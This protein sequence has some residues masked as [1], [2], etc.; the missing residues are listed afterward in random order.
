MIERMWHHASTAEVL[1]LVGSDPENG[2]TRLEVESRQEQFGPNA[3]P[4]PRGQGPVLRFLL[5]FHQPLLYILLVAAVITA[6]MREWVDAS[7]IFGVVLVNAIIGFLQESKAAKALEAL[8]KTTLTPARVIRAGE[9]RHIDSCDLVTGDIVLLQ[10]GDKV[11]ADLRLLR[12]R[13]LKIDESALTGESLTTEKLELELPLETPLAERQNMSFASTLVTYGQGRGVVVAI[14]AQTEVGRI[15][16]MISTVNALETPL[17]RKI[18][19]FSRVLLVVILLLAGV[20]FAVGV[21]RGQSSFDMFMAAVALAVGAIPEGLPAAVTITLAIGVSRMARRRAIV[22]KLSAVE[23]LGSTTVI[24]SDKT[25]TLTVNQ[26]TVL[27]IFAGEKLYLT[28]GTGYEATGEIRAN[29]EDARGLADNVEDNVAAKQCLRAGL[30]CNDS[31]LVRGESRWEVQGD[32]TEGA[33]I[34]AARK[35]GLDSIQSAEPMPRQDA[36]PFE[37]QYQY[38]ATL[39]DTCSDRARQ[40]IVKG[41]VEVVL[42]KCIVALNAQ[43]ETIPLDLAT[44]NRKV[45]AMAAKGLRVLA[46]AGKALPQTTKSIT[47][48]DIGELVFF[49]LQGMIDPPRAEALAAIKACQAAGIR[50]KM[51]TGDHALTAHAIARQLGLEGIVAPGEHAPLVRT[52]FDLASTTDEELQEIADET[53]VFARATPELK[54]RLVRALQAKG[55]IVA[56][57]GDGVN[58]AP[59][60]KQANIGVAM[61]IGGTE[62][63]KE[64][65]DMVLT[66]DNFATIEAAVEEGRGVFENLTKYIVWNLPTS[67]GEGLVILAA[68]FAG[69]P[70]PILP[71]QILWINMT[72]AVLLGVMLAFEPKESEIMNMPPRNPETPIL[73]GE[74]IGRIVVVS[75]IMLVGAFGSFEWALGA[76]YN[77]VVART[78]AVNVFVVVELFYLFNCRSLHKSIVEIGLFSNRWIG[79]GVASM[80]VLQ[81]A[82]TYAPFMNQIFHSAP[83][84]WDAWWR[85]L[86]TGVF[87]YTVVGLE[88]SLRRKFA[89]RRVSIERKL[90]VGTH[91]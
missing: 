9:T 91:P 3:I 5:Q 36:I 75:L 73:T 60:L 49:G 12:T 48:D 74:L 79:L 51:I 78:V 72:T 2:L 71:V 85:I 82:F 52:A 84:G 25:G 22:R 88:K 33:L 86:L 66:D 67:M 30:L 70:L 10:S 6:L 17:T 77:E 28:T 8:R 39:H 53:A 58:D 76:G 42:S 35:A 89:P 68:V 26:M 34:A 55:H 15:S 16:E 27:E 43:G 46:F 56:M 29:E 90:S 18:A 44:V 37:S 61:G 21:W 13:D 32:P 87:V 59:A 45:E 19:K 63:A 23:T 69:V 11:P 64:A 20:T 40:L 83:I 31:Q 4:V 62:V 24:C 80:I 14:G 7:V 47:H 1:G 41:A 57:T 50:V 38:M 54:L 65:A 81:L